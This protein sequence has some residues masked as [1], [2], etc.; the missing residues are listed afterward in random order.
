MKKSPNVRLTSLMALTAALVAV[1]AFASAAGARSHRRCSLGAGPLT[2]TL[3]FPCNRAT[4]H[5]GQ[6]LTLR[7]LDRNATA[8][9][10][11]PEG[12]RS[13]SRRPFHLW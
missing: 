12:V 9:R 1:L 2:P 7:V 3:S 6:N 4:V 13:G 11:L 10:A 5:L 8:H